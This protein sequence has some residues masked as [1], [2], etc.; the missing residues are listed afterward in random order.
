MVKNDNYYTIKTGSGVREI[1]V[2]PSYGGGGGG[3]VDIS[4]LVTKQEIKNYYTKAEIDKLNKGEVL[5]TDP[6]QVPTT[7][8]GITK[9]RT[10]DK[11]PLVEVTR[12]LLY[13]YQDPSIA[14]FST[15]KTSLT[16]GETLTSPI[17]VSW[18]ITNTQNVKQGSIELKLDNKKINTDSLGFSATNKTFVITPITLNN[19]GSK[20]LVLS[21]RNTNGKEITK[22]VNITWYNTII[23]GT[24]DKIEITSDDVQLLTKLNANSIGRRYAF[25]ANGYKWFLIPNSWTATNFI[26]SDTQFEVPM[27]EENTINITNQFGVEQTYRVYRSVNRL[28]GA[29]NMNIN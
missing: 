1:W 10:F 9:G 14:S 16:I 23:Y 27:R 19:K 25:P 15:T 29:I 22:T 5:F 24:I 8:G 28:G 20:Q 11:V 12:D 3:N 13:P 26:D 7:I 2:P 21:L 4:N 6:R 18:N 17:T